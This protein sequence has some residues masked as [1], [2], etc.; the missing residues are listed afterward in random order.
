MSKNAVWETFRAMARVL[1]S[2]MS[3]FLVFPIPMIMLE[4]HPSCSNPKKSKEREKVCTILKPPR[5]RNTIFP[6]QEI[7]PVHNSPRL[8]VDLRRNWESSSAEIRQVSQAVKV[9]YVSPIDSSLHGRGNKSGA[10]CFVSSCGSG[11]GNSK[12]RND[13]GQGCCR[14]LKRDS[15]SVP[16]FVVLP[17]VKRQK[18]I[19]VSMDV[20]EIQQDESFPKRFKVCDGS[21]YEISRSGAGDSFADQGGVGLSLP[22]VVIGDLVSHKTCDSNSCHVMGTSGPSSI[23]MSDVVE[24][25]QS[26]LHSAVSLLHSHTIAHVQSSCNS[27][28]AHPEASKIPLLP[29][30]HHHHTSGSSSPLA[31]ANVVPPGDCTKPIPFHSPLPWVQWLLDHDPQALGAMTPQCFQPFSSST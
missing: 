21:K 24:Q 26:S 19:R 28:T 16:H 12:T 1:L 29:S 10:L 14:G 5:V 2:A 22:H 13:E 11:D 4:N 7:L 25:A 9:A 20:Q 15:S 6:R 23:F 3:P 17:G 8:R 18:Q 31:S 27:N 30:S